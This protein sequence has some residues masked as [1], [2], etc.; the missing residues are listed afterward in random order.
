MAISNIIWVKEQLQG[1]S[2][3]REAMMQ[4]GESTLKKACPLM[5]HFSGNF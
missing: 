2:T 1:P 5:P 4:N 3:A